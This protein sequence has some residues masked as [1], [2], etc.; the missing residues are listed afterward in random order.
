LQVWRLLTSGV[1]THPE[2][3]NHL[4]FSL[5]GLYFLAPDLE[6]RWG[7]ARFLVFLA[8]AVVF[9]NLFVGGTSALASGV[10]KGPF[11]PSMC[12]GPGAALAAVAVGWSQEMPRA[13]IRLFFFLPVTGRALLW[14]ALGF[15]ALGFVYPASVPE[16]VVAPF[17][18]IVAGLLLGGSPSPVRSLLLRFRLGRLRR[19]A[20]LD[21]AAESGRTSSTGRRG[22]G[23]PPLRVV[24]GGLEEELRRRKPPK[25]KRYLN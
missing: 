20:V 14:F 10:D 19:A 23:S 13:E 16:G 11:H 15:A 6:R 24:Y 1:L 2:S 22:A 5:I 17:G 4:L 18:G 7:T 3:F 21:R 12:F 8:A 9:G 25:D